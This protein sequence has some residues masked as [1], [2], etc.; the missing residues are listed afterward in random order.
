M[1]RVGVCWLAGSGQ[2]S[3]WNWGQAPPSLS[4]RGSSSPRKGGMKLPEEESTGGRKQGSMQTPAPRELE[5]CRSRTARGI[6]GEYCS[7]AVH[8]CSNMWNHWAVQILVPVFRWGNGVQ[9][10]SIF[11]RWELLEGRD[12]VLLSSAPSA[13]PDTV[14]GSFLVGPGSSGI[15]PPSQISSEWLGSGALS[16]VPSEWIHVPLEGHSPRHF[17]LGRSWEIS[18]RRLSGPC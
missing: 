16:P 10:K 17:E 4:A 3:S 11:R 13:A 15:A 14:P 6:R 12:H 18:Q 8:R 2:G 1:A 9:E 7:P 5:V